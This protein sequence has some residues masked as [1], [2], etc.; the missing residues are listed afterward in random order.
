MRSSRPAIDREAQQEEYR[1][2]R[3]RFSSLHREV[4]GLRRR[5]HQL[6]TLLQSVDT[7]L[8]A[9]CRQASFDGDK[10]SWSAV[11]QPIVVCRS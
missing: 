11:G 8:L 2:L 5:E 4:D 3:E 7:D 9:V 6:S 1:L 10:S